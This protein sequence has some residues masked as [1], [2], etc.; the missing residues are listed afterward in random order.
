[1]TTNDTQFL[2]E[3]TQKA[4]SNGFKSPYGQTFEEQ[5]FVQNYFKE[6]GILPQPQEVNYWAGQ[7]DKSELTYIPESVMGRLGFRTPEE[8]SRAQR[9]G[10]SYGPWVDEGYGSVVP[11]GGV[12]TTD[13]FGNPSIRYMDLTGGYSGREKVRE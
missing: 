13:E 2:P 3:E 1:M 6:R 10:E 8:Y 4:L 9:V 12:V 11:S 7:Q 5:E